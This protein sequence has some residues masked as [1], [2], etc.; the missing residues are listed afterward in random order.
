MIVFLDT[1]LR[2][3]LIYSEQGLKKIPFNK[4]SSIKSQLDGQKALYITN[5]IEVNGNQVVDT[6]MQYLQSNGEDV[7][8]II[9]DEPQFLCAASKGSIC[10]NELDLTV[11][12]KTDF[13]PLKS[14]REKY[15]EDFLEN[16][17]IKSLIANKKLEVISLSEVQ[18]RQLVPDERQQAYEAA[19]ERMLTGSGRPGE[20]AE[21]AE[22][23]TGEDGPEDAI[24]IDLNKG[25]SFSGSETSGGFTGNE[26]GL[27]LDDFEG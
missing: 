9:V 2:C 13:I 19:L 27:L 1:Q 10:I 23:G 26:S 18:E 8:S 25:H 3:V 21:L 7:R 14:L 11:R 12:G 6:V 15:G 24:S 4:I 17:I 16:G 20:A 22:G 5:A